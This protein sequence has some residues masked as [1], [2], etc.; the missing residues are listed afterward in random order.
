MG[1]TFCQSSVTDCINEGCPR[2][3][4]PSRAREQERSGEALAMSQFKDESCGYVER[5]N[6]SPA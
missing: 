4:T 1:I 5:D 2:N 3:F 6:Q